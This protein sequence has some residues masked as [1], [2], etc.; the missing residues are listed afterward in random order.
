MS[1]IAAEAEVAATAATAAT[2]GSQQELEESAKK[3]EVVCN[4]SSSANSGKSRPGTGGHGVGKT[5]RKHSKTPKQ[6]KGGKTAAVGSSNESPGL[7]VTAD[8]V[9]PNGRA[10]MSKSSGV[11]VERRRRGSV[12]T[13]NAETYVEGDVTKAGEWREAAEAL[14]G[15]GTVAQDGLQA[16]MDGEALALQALV[17]PR[18]ARYPKYAGFASCC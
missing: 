6:S 7:V 10:N 11:V 8:Y 2:R 1:A 16:A 13:E 5:K 15:R 18:W 17:P 14:F 12:G 4:D 9:H 3:G